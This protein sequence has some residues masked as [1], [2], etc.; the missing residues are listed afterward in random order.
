MTPMEQVKPDQLYLPAYKWYDELRP[1]S[2]DDIFR[3]PEVKTEVVEEEKK[4]RFSH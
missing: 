4:H 2:P 3:K 1:T